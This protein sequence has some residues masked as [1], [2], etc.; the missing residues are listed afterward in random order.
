MKSVV[1]IVVVR[2]QDSRNRG[3]SHAVPHILQGTLDPGVASGGI[4]LRDPDN[5][6]ADLRKDAAPSRRRGVRPFPCDEVSMPAQNRVGRDDRRDLTEAMPAQP[7]P[8]HGQPTSFLLG[9]ADPAA[10]CARRMRFSSTR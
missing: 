4:L 8:V 10:Q 5:Q 7:M 3:A 2:L 1:L 9:Q 6:P